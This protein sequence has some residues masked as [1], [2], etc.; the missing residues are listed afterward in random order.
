M[1]AATGPDSP[2]SELRDLL[3]SAP[4]STS[5][6]VL[7]VALALML[8]ATVLLLV[9]RRTLREEYTPIWIAVAFATLVLSLS[10]PLLWGLTRAIGAWTPSSTLFFLGELFLVAICLNYAVRLSKLTLQ[11][12]NLAQ[13]L[14]VLRAELTESAR[15]PKA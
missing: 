10:Q 14:A 6:R 2:L 8:V 9:R 11:V 1:R 13:E 4:E 7:F 12:K 5:T 3:L 15:P